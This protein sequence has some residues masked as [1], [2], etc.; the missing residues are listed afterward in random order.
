MMLS[1]RLEKR[2]SQDLIVKK[3]SETLEVIKM[4]YFTRIS[5]HKYKAVVQ[6]L[7]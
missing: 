6:K 7:K 2:K 1:R 3:V 4:A 5:N